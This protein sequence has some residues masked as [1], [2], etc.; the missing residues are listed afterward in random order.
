MISLSLQDT[1]E[2]TEER[3]SDE[4]LEHTLLIFPLNDSSLLLVSSPSVKC[5]VLKQRTHSH[6]MGNQLRP[7]YK[8]TAGMFSTRR[9]DKILVVLVKSD[10]RCITWH[11]TETLRNSGSRVVFPGTIRS[12]NFVLAYYTRDKTNHTGGN[13]SATRFGHSAN[14][15]NCPVIK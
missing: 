12:S 5:L 11:M 13:Q 6:L 2:V 3:V 4:Y 1:E 9:C 15:T 7:K 8:D 14:R 10:Y